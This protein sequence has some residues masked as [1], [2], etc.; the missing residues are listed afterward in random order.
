MKQGGL[1]ILSA[2]LENGRGRNLSNVP[3][4]ARAAAAAA[5]AVVH[6]KTTYGNDK[7]GAITP[8]D[9]LF[10]VPRENVPAMGSGSGVIISSDGYIVTN[11]HLVEGATD[12]EIILPD[13][14]SFKA[15]QIG[16]D[17]NTDLALLKVNGKKLPVVEPGNSDKAQVGDW[18]LA[19][20]YPFSLSSTVTAGIISAKGRSIGI[21]DRT[22][23]QGSSEPEDEEVPGGSAIESFIQTDAAIN[24]GNSGGAL[25]T[26][27]GKLIGINAA[28]ASQTGGYEGYGFAIP[29][30]LVKKI[31]A[32]FRKY[33][34]VRRG[35]LGVRFPAPS[36]EEQVLRQAGID[37]GSINGV[38]LTGVQPG[39]AAAVAGL[40]SGDII[41]NIDGAKINST[42]EFTERIARHR[43]GDKLKIAYLRGKKK[44]TVD[45]T[46]RGDRLAD[47]AANDASAFKGFH[48]K[49]GATFAPIP[50]AVKERYHLGSGVVVT[51]L[52]PDGIFA[53]A[54]IPQ[55]TVITNVNGRPINTLSDLDLALG[56]AGNGMIRIDGIT[57]DGTGFV[58]NFPLGA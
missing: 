38:Y 36:I 33:G 13:K 50:D 51:S 58:F 21:L 25:V 49:L 16:R 44:D 12:L 27:D 7:T 47:L 29:V 3:D 6:I 20:G 42:A 1:I 55:G 17:P 19:V 53:T 10:G 26:A 4:F 15:K 43:P 32:D 40:K 9:Y 5:P 54:G 31:V 11:N 22:S 37:P 52:D 39:S 48:Q 46:L 57:P 34:E 23:K 45:V 56:N 35:Y 14:R 28:I 41:Q 24:P 18:V 30:N 8:Y 2:L